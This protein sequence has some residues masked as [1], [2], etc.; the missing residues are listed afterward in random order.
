MRPSIVTT[1]A[2]ALSNLS[3]ARGA[4]IVTISNGTVLGST[5]GVVDTFSGIPYAQP[6][7][8][9]LRFRPSLALN[10]TFGIINATGTPRGCPQLPTNADP[11]VLGQV[12]AQDLEPYNLFFTPPST[13]GEDCLTINVQ[14][15]YS[16]TAGS[17]L[18]VVFWIYG[19][20]FDSGSTQAND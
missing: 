11:H 3:L 10:T 12:P 6:P 17:K 5:S 18:P 13:T 4:A 2:A 9:S 14:R 8:G 15:P 20:G 7:I 16:A 19:G 1:W